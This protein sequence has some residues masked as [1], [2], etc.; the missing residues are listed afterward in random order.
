MMLFGCCNLMRNLQSMI[1]PEMFSMQKQMIHNMNPDQPKSND[2]LFRKNDSLTI[3]NDTTGKNEDSSLA[4]VQKNDTDSV[5]VS[6][7]KMNHTLNHPSV[8][9]KITEEIEQAMYVSD[10]GSSWLKRFGLIGLLPSIIYLLAGIFLLL[11]KKY[12]INL[13]YIALLLSL[14]LNIMEIGVF[15]QDTSGYMIKISTLSGP[16][17]SGVLDLV[18]LIVLATCDKTNYLKKPLVIVKNATDEKMQNS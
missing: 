5:V 7:D 18:L 12:S 3:V 17:I 2:S 14:A 6:S 1:A 11:R 16:I 9:N 10:Y 13:A 8:P 15:S 4:I